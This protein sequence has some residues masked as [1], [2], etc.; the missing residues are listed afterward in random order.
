LPIHIA[1][2]I[3]IIDIFFD[4]IDI[5][6]DAIA[7]FIFAAITPD[8]TCRRFERDARSAVRANA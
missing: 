7:T 1:A 3:I 5:T 4:T 6:P 8:A 2:F